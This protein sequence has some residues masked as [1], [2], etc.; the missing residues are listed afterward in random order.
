MKI[1]G[2]DVGEKRIGV[3]KADSEV[4]I[5]VPVGFVEVNGKEW[6]EL[7]KIARLN[8]TSFFVLGL[9]RSN[10]GNE[11]KQTLFVRSFARVLTEKIP[12]AKVR[13]QDE[14]L[15]SIE[16]E[17]RL[18]ARKKNYAKGEIDAEAATIILQDF[19]EGF[20]S[21]VS[22][23]KK[24]KVKDN[25]TS[26]KVAE[27]PISKTIKMAEKQGQKVALKTKKVSSKL[28]KTLI[29]SPIVLLVIIA[30]VV[31]SVIWR[32]N[33][34][35]E[36]EQMWQDLE[37]QMTPDVFSFTIRPGE[38]IFDIKAALVKQG[39]SEEAVEMAFEADYSTEEGLEFLA[40]R[41]KDATLEGY[42]FGE[43]HEFY[44]DTP[45]DEILKTFLLGM[46]KVIR[47]N[48]LE[49]KYKAQGLTL[50]EGITL[51]SIV[52]KE[53]PTNEQPTVAQVF[54]SRLEYGMTL[55]SDVTVSYA[56][57][58]LDP[59]RKLYKDNEAALLVESCYNTRVNAGLPCGPISNPGLSALLA[60]AEPDDTSYLYFLTGDDGLMYYSYTDSEHFQ[61]AALHCQELCNVS[62]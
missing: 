54:L 2:L 52:Q 4:R 25:K 53:A 7:A 34:L 60:V 20:K 27:Q 45:V 29:I 36:R 3:S 55:G 40:E 26:E 48:D 44:A 6:E 17:N 16:A 35:R 18:K 8:N 12:G 28:R 38:T 9:P 21:S 57:D 61:N 22:P 31:G 50:F 59:E 10:E 43:T 42:L 11:T 15:T 51:A 14:S 13:F 23:E 37:A 19:I 32:Q 58:I 49:T 1:I 62:L 56:L 30:V 33:Q 24:L 39:Y 47:E 41:P 46:G 5:A